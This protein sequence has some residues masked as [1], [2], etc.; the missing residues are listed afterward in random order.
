MADGTAPRNRA[1][2]TAEED[3]RALAGPARLDP[4][5]ARELGRTVSAIRRRRSWVRRGGAVPATPLIDRIPSHLA[6]RLGMRL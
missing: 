1:R 2:W 5:L 3:R 4:Q 6:A